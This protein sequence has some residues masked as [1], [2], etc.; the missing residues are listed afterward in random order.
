MLRLNDFGLVC[1]SYELIGATEWWIRSTHH[2]VLLCLSGG[3]G[4]CDRTSGYC[5]AKWLRDNFRYS[6]RVHP[7]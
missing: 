2:V 6:S 1:G 4:A 7:T 3:R 5:N